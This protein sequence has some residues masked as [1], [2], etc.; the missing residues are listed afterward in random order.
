M[1][2]LVH[3][4]NTRETAMFQYKRKKISKPAY[5]GAMQITSL[6]KFYLS[7]ILLVDSGIN[8]MF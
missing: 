3:N 4:T 7:T 5:E 8:V 6:Y 1:Y 2:H